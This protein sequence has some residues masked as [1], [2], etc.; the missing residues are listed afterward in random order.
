[1]GLFRMIYVLSWYNFAIFYFV[2]F[3][4]IIWYY[5]FPRSLHSNFFPIHLCFSFDVALIATQHLKKILSIIL[6]ISCPFPIYLF[7]FSWNVTSSPTNH[8]RKCTSSTILSLHLETPINFTYLFFQ[9]HTTINIK[10]QIAFLSTCT[11][12]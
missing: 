5:H 1:M 9:K 11:T 2:I 3:Y 4:L 12:V 8:A 6:Y 7:S 10:Q